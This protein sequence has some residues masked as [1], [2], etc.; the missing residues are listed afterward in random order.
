V[1]TIC[2]KILDWKAFNLH[3]GYISLK[4]FHLAAL[5]AEVNEIGT[6]RRFYDGWEGE[7]NIWNAHLT[8][9]HKDNAV[10]KSNLNK[11]STPGTS[12]H[13]FSVKVSL[14]TRTWN[15]SHGALPE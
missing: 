11:M 7:Q 1:E 4:K 3:Q 10:V 8:K 6:R 12:F 13:I 5:F 9:S 14:C 15:I 2:K